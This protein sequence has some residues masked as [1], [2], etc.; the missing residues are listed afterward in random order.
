MSTATIFI[1][2]ALVVYAF[3]FGITRLVLSTK[4]FKKQPQEDQERARKQLRL[5]LLI[6]PIILIGCYILL[7][8]PPEVVGMMPLILYV[9]M[10]GFACWILW[11]SY[12]LGIRRDE[13]L[14][15]ALHGKFLPNTQSIITQFAIA[16]LLLAIGIIALLVAIP[17]LHINFGSWGALFAAV[18]SIYG[19]FVSNQ[20]RKIKNQ[21]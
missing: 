9:A 20:E 15:K 16:N 3:T 18:T 11:R 7:I 8:S 5:A 6:S 13:R 14:V 12:R 1:G 4:E 19:L 21:P 17:V 2:T 10:A